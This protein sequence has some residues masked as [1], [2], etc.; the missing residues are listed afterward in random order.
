MAGTV[1]K[2]HELLSTDHRLVKQ[3]RKGP[4]AQN[5]AKSHSNYQKIKVFISKLT[6]KINQTKP[7]QERRKTN[8]S[9]SLF[10]L[11]LGIEP[12]P[13]TC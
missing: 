11:V 5:I 9:L 3:K 7:K 2:I 4:T 6:V 1:S 10:L 13:S 8:I 12:R